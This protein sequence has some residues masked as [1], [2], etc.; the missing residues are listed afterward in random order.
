MAIPR[1]GDIDR[2]IG[3]PKPPN[4][5]P[6]PNVKGGGKIPTTGPGV[7]KGGKVVGRV[8]IPGAR[9]I[10]Q[11]DWDEE[12]FDPRKYGP[13]PEIP[14]SPLLPTTARF[15]QQYGPPTP[16][17]SGIFGGKSGRGWNEVG[18]GVGLNDPTQPNK[19]ATGLGA[20]AANLQGILSGVGGGYG[21]DQ[22]GLTGADYPAFNRGN[23]NMTGYERWGSGP[24]LQEWY[25]GRNQ[26]TNPW[27]G[28]LAGMTPEGMQ[29][30]RGQ[31]DDVVAGYNQQRYVNSDA[32]GSRYG[33]RAAMYPQGGADTR[34]MNN[35]GQM[36]YKKGF[37]PFTAEQLKQAENWDKNWFAHLVRTGQVNPYKVV[38]A[39]GGGGGGRG[40]GGGGGGGYGGSGYQSPAWVTG[41]MNWRI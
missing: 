10:Q 28:G 15:P 25:A 24:T 22:A 41:L 19:W 1:F 35:M 37:T 38:D 5:E 30:N 36:G 2:K 14:A 20:V 29:Q 4:P 6:N 8:N 11:G 39:G 12:Y 26:T 31:W 34:L 18:A 40:W 32:S 7:S 33:S 13:E 21:R 9:N 16:S 17:W 3:L 27:G 23:P